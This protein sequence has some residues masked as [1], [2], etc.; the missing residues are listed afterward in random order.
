FG[1]K[2]LFG[3]ENSKPQLIS[4]LNAFLELEKKDKIV[5]L[6]FKN[7]EKLGLNII[8]RKAI[9]DIY[10]LHKNENTVIQLTLRFIFVEMPKFNKKESELVTY[11]DKWFYFLKNLDSLDDIPLIYKDEKVI[12]DAFKKAEYLNLPKEDKDSYFQSLKVYRDLHNVID[13]AENEGF[14]KGKEEGKIEG[15][16][17]IIKEMLLDEMPLEKIS[18]ITK[19]S[20]EE[21]ENLKKE[22]ES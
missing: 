1:F 8:D 7:L 22:M 16:I 2:K 18:K 19:L 12:I 3:E 21:I 11:L 13:T 9:F 15:K 14:K 6:E 17:E 20:I 5:D 10:S 4:F